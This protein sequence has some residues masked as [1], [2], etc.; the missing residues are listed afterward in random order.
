MTGPV[1]LPE[2]GWIDPKGTG[3]ARDLRFL[4][5]PGRRSSLRRALGLVRTG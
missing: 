2:K 3:G 1:R 4:G 5:V